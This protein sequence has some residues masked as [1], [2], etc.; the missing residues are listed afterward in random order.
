MP[1]PMQEPTPEMVWEGRSLAAGYYA[2]GAASLIPPPKFQRLLN[3]RVD[4]GS[5]DKRGGYTSFQAGGAMTGGVAVNS[6]YST[7]ST[8]AR[9][10]VAA[11]NTRLFGID[12]AGVVAV[13]S[14]SSPSGAR[15]DFCEFDAAG[16]ISVIGYTNTGAGFAFKW[17]SAAA[18]VTALGGPGVACGVVMSH[19]RRI[20]TATGRTIYVTEPDTN[21]TYTAGFSLTIKDNPEYG[22]ITK[23]VSFARNF[24]LI[25][26]ER[27]MYTM[28]G[29]DPG[30]ISGVPDIVI[31]ALAPIGCPST[32]GTVKVRDELYF[33]GVDEGQYG[34]F[35]TD[36]TDVVKLT[37]DLEDDFDTV[38]TAVLTTVC[39][40]KLGSDVL[41]SIPLGAATDGSTIYLIHRETPRRPIVTWQFAVMPRSMTW[42]RLTGVLYFGSQAAANVYYHTPTTYNDDTTAI[43]MDVITG[44]FSMPG[45][46][47]HR[48]IDLEEIEAHAKVVASGSVAVSLGRD[49]DAVGSF[50]A[51]DSSPWSTASSGTFMGDEGGASYAWQG[52]S[53]YLFHADPD[54]QAQAFRFRFREN[55]TNNCQ[56]YRMRAK[57]SVRK[58]Q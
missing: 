27:G 34:I 32:W 28:L 19:S 4:R 12:T 56:L 30:S 7:Y 3:V 21:D 13:L 1:R 5:I 14:T 16:T 57:G 22:N 55:S 46:L 23:M 25:M 24:A 44:P 49:D 50:T 35:M 31:K 33:F 38:N 29:S 15:Y 36:S 2:L 41:F 11:A 39:A 17:D 26:C 45:A 54:T 40:A 6:V 20:W 58:E 8:S 43:D 52:V 47:G 9:K 42:N 37:R 53:R 48:R 18:S 51:L 10:V